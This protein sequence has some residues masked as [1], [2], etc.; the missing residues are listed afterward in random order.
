MSQLVGAVCDLTEVVYQQLHSNM[1][2]HL[3]ASQAAQ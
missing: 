1:V 2:E 3:Q